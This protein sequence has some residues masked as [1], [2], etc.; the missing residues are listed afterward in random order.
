M[1]LRGFIVSPAICSHSEGKQKSSE[2]R[3]ACRFRS[4]GCKPRAKLSSSI[5]YY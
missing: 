3:N 5:G 4:R 1:T 2:D